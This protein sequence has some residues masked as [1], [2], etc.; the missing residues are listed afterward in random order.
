MSQLQTASDPAVQ[1]TQSLLDALTAGYAP[2]DFAVRFWD[3]SIRDPEPGQNARFTLVLQHPGALRKMFWPPHRMPL[4][5]AYIYDDFDIEGDIHAFFRL[6]HYLIAKN[7]TL[8]ERLRLAARLLRLPSVSRAQPG[9]QA[10][11]LTGRMHSIER[12]KQAISYHYDLSNDFF[13]LWLDPRMVYSCAYFADANES[14]D[15]AQ[16]RKLDYLCRKLRLQPGQRLLDIGC[17]WGGLVLYA[18]E[19]YGV[20]VLGI[21]LS[22]RQM[23]L[24]DERIRAAGLQERCQV[25]YRDY[26][27][28][29]ETDHFDKV[30]SVGMAE[31]L[32]EAMLP[33]LFRAVWRV[34]KPQGVFLNQAIT[35]KAGIRPPRW[36]AFSHRYVFPDGEL[37][38]VTDT[39]RAA[40]AAGFDIRDVENLREHYALTLERWVARLEENRDAAREA[41]DEATY[42]VFRLYL[43]GARQGFLRGVYNLYQ[44]LLSKPAGGNSNLPL[45]RGDWYA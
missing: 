34:L 5:E 33:T 14:V 44:T 8:G 19:R 29:T 2:R 26:R 41:T 38:P 6:I 36:T 21:T 10:A 37:R 13:A 20:D 3:G 23:E 7:W 22:R 40:E 16:G 28:L 32:G 12:D 17:G 24:A 15:V 11:R 4:G 1:Q 45:A 25:E 30:V 42:R 43:A 35:L 18:A 9:R 31:H 39:L 27:E